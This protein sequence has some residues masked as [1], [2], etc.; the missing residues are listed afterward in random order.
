MQI[1]GP[2]FHIID[3]PTHFPTHI[4]QKYASRYYGKHIF[5]KR[6]LAL[7]IEHIT[8]CPPERP[9]EE[10]FLPIW[11]ALVTLLV[12]RIAIFPLFEPF[13][14]LIF[15][16]FMCIFSLR[17]PVSSNDC[18]HHTCKFMNFVRHL[19]LSLYFYYRIHPPLCK[20]AHFPQ[21][22]IPALGG[23]HKFESGRNAK[24]KKKCLFGPPANRINAIF[25][26]PIAPR[27][28]PKTI[29]SAER[30][31]KKPLPTDHDVNLYQKCRLL[32][33]SFM[34]LMI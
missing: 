15:A 22:P 31:D 24:S 9:Q 23:K 25:T 11:L 4:F 7:P 16:H 13:G 30:A 14:I 6:I 28:A 33:A 19:L 32:V 29:A 18:I 8:L 5:A 10:P 17:S 12:V 34:I 1:A 20:I 21:K 2:L 27:F 3:A 26:P